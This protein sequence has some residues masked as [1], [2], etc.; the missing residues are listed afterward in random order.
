MAPDQMDLDAVLRVADMAQHYNAKTTDIAAFL[1][2]AA[3]ER[4][5]AARSGVSASGGSLTLV[6]MRKD[7]DVVRLK[8]EAKFLLS[9]AEA[10]SLVPRK[11]SKTD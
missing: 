3:S 6:A 5:V 9:S 4:R 11:N 7:W 8:T 10:V 2:A 1:V